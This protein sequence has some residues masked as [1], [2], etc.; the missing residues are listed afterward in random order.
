MA[1]TLLTNVIVP[2]LYL[3]YQAV[4]SPEKTALVQSGIITLNPALQEAANRA[5][6]SVEIPFWNDL[7]DSVEPNY[8]TDSPSDIA[9]PGAVTASEML[10]RKSYLN[11]GFSSAD[12]VA[13]L[14]GSDPM[15]RI[16]N[17]FGTYWTRQFQHRLIAMLSGLYNNNIASYN[18][19]MV[20]KIASESVAGQTAA[21]KFN[22]TSFTDAVFQLGDAF[23][24]ITAIAVHSAVLAQ[25]TKNDD[26]QFIPPSEGV[27]GGYRFMGKLVI[28]DDGCPK[29]PGTTDG[30]VYTS[31]LYGQGAIG[32]GVGTPQVPVAVQRFEKEANGGGIEEIWERKTWLMHPEGYNFTNAAVTGVS[33]TNANLANATNWTRVISRKQIRLGFLVTN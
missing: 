28:V 6:N 9:V 13:E 22:R 14:A 15:Q 5:G 33:P 7:D 32:Y 16:R 17:R 30:F 19:D 20:V 26:I 21:T 31:F 1:S 10:G 18:G 25:M 2:D 4:N 12:L 29:R 11:W 3:A 8:S 24:Q 27:L 23:D